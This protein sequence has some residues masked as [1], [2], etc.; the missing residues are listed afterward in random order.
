M[1]NTDEVQKEIIINIKS[2]LISKEL[3]SFEKYKS[4]DV[5]KAVLENNAKNIDEFFMLLEL[6]NSIHLQK[7]KL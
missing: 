7:K 6:G 1:Y 5:Y 4:I 3:Y 2:E